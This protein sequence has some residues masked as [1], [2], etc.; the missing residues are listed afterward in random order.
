MVYAT[1]PK[2]KQKVDETKIVQNIEKVGTYTP[3]P[4]FPRGE[5]PKPEPKPAPKPIK[6]TPRATTYVKNDVV[7]LARTLNAQRFGDQHWDAL[8]NIIVRESGWNINAINRSSGACGLF[9]ALPCS[10]M[11]GMEVNNQL[12]WGLSYIA[13]RYGTPTGAWKF[14]QAHGWY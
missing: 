3:L 6:V 7:A 11:G 12:N 1:K 13:N 8:Y 5:Y 9:Q 4:E 2:T 14:W 10:K